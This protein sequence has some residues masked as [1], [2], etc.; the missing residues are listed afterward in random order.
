MNFRFYYVFRYREQFKY[1]WN[2]YY[3][4]LSLIDSQ[5]SH[6]NISWKY[7]CKL[8]L[9]QKPDN[10]AQNSRRIGISRGMFVALATSV[11]ALTVTDISSFILINLNIET[12]THIF[13]WKSCVQLL[14]K[15]LKASIKKFFLK[16][17]LNALSEL[18]YL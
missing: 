10:L 2:N 3:I 8:Y 13:I 5:V 12:F 6:R 11:L 9:K 17:W 4:T 15:Y 16:V 7:T 1:K 18:E 14:Q